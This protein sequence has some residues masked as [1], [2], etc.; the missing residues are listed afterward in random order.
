MINYLA[1]FNY[2]RNSD[3]HMVDSKL[4]N[5]NH[6]TYYQF[7]ANFGFVIFSFVFILIIIIIV[8]FILFGLFC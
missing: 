7:I 4:L 2:F 3:E 1:N 6:I 5:I 8:I